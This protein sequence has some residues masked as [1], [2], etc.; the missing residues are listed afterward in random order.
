MPQKM[1][2]YKVY[3]FFINC[4]KHYAT[5][6]PKYNTLIDLAVGK[7]GIF[8]KRPVKDTPKKPRVF[9]VTPA[10]EFEIPNKYSTEKHNEFKNSWW[11]CDDEFSQMT[12]LIKE[13]RKNWAQGTKKKDKIYLFHKYVASLDV[14]IASKILFG[15]M[16]TFALLLKLFK[17]SD[18][19][20]KNYRVA[21]VNENFLKK[22]MFQNL[23]FE[24]DY[25][26]PQTRDEPALPFS[27]T[28]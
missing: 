5:D 23:Q 10:G 16:L 7:R 20:Y 11:G 17:S 6:D 25:S 1:T 4:S 14:S 9:L 22:E 13:S 24:Y 15:A 26:V 2:Q 21:S 12:S 18:I 3:P 19:V 8:I 27:T 28:E